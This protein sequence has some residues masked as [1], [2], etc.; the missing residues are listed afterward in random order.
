VTGSIKETHQTCCYSTPSLLFCFVHLFVLWVWFF[1]CF[2]MGV[3]LYSSGCPGTRYVDQTSLKQKS[4]C[5]CLLNTRIKDLAII[6]NIIYN[7]YTYTHIYL[8]VCICM[9][10]CIC[11][12]TPYETWYLWKSEEEV[13][14]PGN[15]VMESCEPPCGC[16]EPDLGSLHEQRVLLTAETSSWPQHICS[17]CNP[18]SHFFINHRNR[19]S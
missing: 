13:R 14:S 17:C 18:L 3:S 6:Y 4:A 16:W 15:G 7:I 5:L 1:V 9:C 8:C 2:E 11:N 12:V 10:I 19:D